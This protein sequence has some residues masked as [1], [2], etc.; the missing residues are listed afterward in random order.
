M[1]KYLDPTGV[2]LLW[3]KIKQITKNN[4]VYYS[5]TT[6]EWNKDISFISE[7]NVLYIYTDYKTITKDDKQFYIPGLKVGDGKAYLIDLPFLNSGGG[8]DVEKL[9]QELIDHIN[10]ATIHIT[11]SEREFWNN[12]LNLQLQNENLILNRE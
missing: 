10:N 7:K 5:N 3:S 9:Q 8:E 11:A 1:P 4:L 12:K 2:A 6:K